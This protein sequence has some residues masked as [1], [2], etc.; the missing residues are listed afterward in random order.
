MSIIPPNPVV[1]QI[2]ADSDALDAAVDEFNRLLEE[3]S[4]EIPDAFAEQLCAAAEGFEKFV[5]LRPY[6]GPAL[7]AG[8]SRMVLEPSEFF[9][10]L[11]AA[12]RTRDFDVGIFVE[13]HGSSSAGCVD[14]TSEE[15][16]PT[17]SQGSVGA[18]PTN[19]QGE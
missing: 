11:L 17:E 7:P 2:T 4:S 16:A 12:L 9:N 19:S 5:N 1:V 13:L 3:L 10:R 15:R 8:E 14:S 6:V 18:C